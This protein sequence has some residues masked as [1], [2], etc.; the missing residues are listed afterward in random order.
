MGDIFYLIVEGQ[1]ALSDFDSGIRGET[2]IGVGEYFGERALLSGSPRSATAKA[3]TKGVDTLAIF[4]AT[5]LVLTSY[6]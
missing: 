6:E 2:V 3:Q 1:V 4:Y 5:R